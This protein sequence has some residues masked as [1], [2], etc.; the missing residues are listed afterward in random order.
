MP[1]FEFTSPEGKTFEVEGPDGST[2]EQA[3][4]ILQQRIGQPRQR[5]QDPR[6]RNG[7][8][9]AAAGTGPIDAA[10]IGAGRAFTQLGRGIGGVFGLDVGVDKGADQAYAALQNARPI[11]TAIGESAPY[12]AAGGLAGAGARSLGS[13]AL[14]QSA[15]GGTVGV[16]MPGSLEERAHRA[17]LDAGLGAAGE[18]GGRYLARLGG[19]GLKKAGNATQDIVR[20]ARELGFRV[21]PSSTADSKIL[22]QVVEGGLESTPGGASVFD[23]I[24]SHNADRLAKLTGDAIGIDR[25]VTEISADVIDEAFDKAG[26]K[27]S[28]LM[29]RTLKVPVT[30]D[31][32]DRIIAIDTD[33]VAPMIAGP[34]DPVRVA[35]D[36]TLDFFERNFEKG[37]SASEIQAQSS[38]LG[39]TATTAMRTNPELGMALFDIQEALLDAARARMGKE[40]AKAFDN[41]RGQ[42]RAL[43]LLTDGR[44]VDPATG[45]IRV[46]S[47]SNTM[48]R[49]DFKGFGRG[50]NQ[51][52]WYKAVKFLARVQPPLKSSGTAERS[53][54]QRML[55]SG[56]TPATAGAGGFGYLTGGP[57]GAVIAPT[58]GANLAARAYV[59]PVAENWLTRTVTPQTFQIARGLGLLGGYSSAQGLDR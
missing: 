45:A 50:K 51:G 57:I 32:L 6:A 36:R 33:R 21:L 35:V 12:M 24:A 30:D 10:L 17:A 54:L 13:A 41:V 28:R 11:A 4:A 31:M 48:Q 46:G 44:N 8:Q 37:I 26:A 27:F 29:S 16:S 43:K 19:L 3:F 9:K 15:A 1:V 52:A 55:Q 53:Q 22:R 34:A 20:D 7:Y 2:K 23:R 59:S 49:K 47:L 14:R 42:Y 39:R 40:S 25:P 58:V 38:K 18:V 56:T 5:G